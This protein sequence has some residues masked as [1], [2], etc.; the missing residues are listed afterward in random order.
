MERPARALLPEVVAMTEQLPDVMATTE[1][2]ISRLIADTNPNFPLT[3]V[4]AMRALRGPQGAMVEVAGPAG[5]GADVVFCTGSHTLRREV[6]SIAGRAQGSFNREVAHAAEHIGYC[7]ELL[8]QVPQGT[9]A[10]RLV[11]RF[12]GSRPDPAQLGKY[13]SV[14]LTIVDP[15]GTLLFEGPLAPEEERA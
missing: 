10:L 2:N 6:K 9:N 1:R 8:V 4:N 14:H 12:R 3:R 15:S 7:G 13:R 11:S 5:Q